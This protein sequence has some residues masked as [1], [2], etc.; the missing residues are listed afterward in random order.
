MLNNFIL[1]YFSKFIINDK[2]PH[3]VFLL[4]FYNDDNY[5]Y[6]LKSKLKNILKIYVNGIKARER[7]DNINV[8]TQLIFKHKPKYIFI[9]SKLKKHFNNKYAIPRL[10][11]HYLIDKQTSISKYINNIFLSYDIRFLFNIKFKNLNNLKNLYLF[12][13]KYYYDDDTFVNCYNLHINIKK[14][15]NLCK[16]YN[17]TSDSSDDSDLNDD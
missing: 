6:I 8:N 9:I 15:I 7:I 14:Y 13:H 16:D 12:N 4:D 5:F 10:Y 2:L 11:F 3:F 17:Y 1:I